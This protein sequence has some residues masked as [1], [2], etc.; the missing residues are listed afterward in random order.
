MSFSD[1]SLKSGVVLSAD[2]PGISPTPLTDGYDWSWL[3]LCRPGDDQGNSGACTIFTF[4]NWA[5]IMFGRS[6]SDADTLAVYAAALSRYNLS[7]GSGL[8]FAQAFAVASDAGWLPGIRSMLPARDLSAL[9]GQPILAAG[10]VTDAW[11]KPSP[12][13]CLDHDPSLTHI[14]AYHAYLI[15]AAGAVPNLAGRWITLENSWSLSWGWN[16][17]GVMREDL[18]ARLC[19]ELWI[20]R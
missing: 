20:L 7:A 12:Q 8:Q 3:P 5:E 13:G 15:V 4:A 14:R 17:L 6:I 11:A 18:H 16:G 10:S 19:R 2:H 1:L 9:S